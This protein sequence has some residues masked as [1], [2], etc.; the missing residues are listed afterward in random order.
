MK[1]KFLVILILTV[2]LAPIKRVFASG[3]SWDFD[4]KSTDGDGVNE[5]NFSLD[6]GTWDVYDYGAK[7][8]GKTLDT[9]AIQKAIDLCH[10]AGGGRVYLHNGIFY[11]ATIY[12]KSHVTL[13]VEAGATL[14]GSGDA[15]DYANTASD[16]PTYDGDYTSKALIYAENVINITIEGRGTI[17]GNGHVIDK[18][19]LTDAYQ[20]PSFQHRPRI[21]HMRGVENI[22]IRDITLKNSASWVQTYQQCRNLVIDGITVDS[23]ENKDIEQANREHSVKHRNTDGLDIVD[24]ELVRIANCY[25]NA[26]DDGIVLK[27][28][29]PDKACRDIVITNCVLSSGASGIKIGT[30]TTGRFEDILVQN[31]VVF[32]T[33]GEGIAIMTADGAIIQRVNISNIT[34]RNIKRQAIFIRLSSRNKKFGTHTV[35]NSPVLKDIIIHNIKGTRLSPLGC[36]ITGLVDTP[37]ENIV[38]S[39]LDLEFEGGLTDV[40]PNHQVP[41]KPN[42]SPVGGMFGNYLPS[43]GFFVRNVKNLRLDQVQLRFAQDD[44]RP[45]MICDNVELLNINGLKAQSIQKTSALIK[46]VNAKEVS[47]SQSRLTGNG[48]VFLEVKGEQS[49]DINLVNN[50]LKGVEQKYVI[51][52]PLLKGIVQEFGT[53]EK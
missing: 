18:R 30:E 20:Y 14:L 46:L 31:C 5:N 50:N 7:G 28:F 42:G 27:S 47:I 17:D 16:Y 53:I 43:Y 33:Y 29:S 41:V 32:D 13:Y 21:I 49:R 51:E 10:K 52:Q 2:V 8:D 22:Q 25:I 24:C 45:A 48:A 26:G 4:S 23:R 36:S 38:L 37:L 34:L 3:Q 11:S 9:E 15:E 12:L 39:N 1:H 44:V 6:S 19:K 35:T 40:D